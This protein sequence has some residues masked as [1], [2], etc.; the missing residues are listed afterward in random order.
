MLQ[1]VAAFEA[2]YRQEFAPGS[3]AAKRFDDNT[4]FLIKIEDLVGTHNAALGEFPD[5]ILGKEIDVST[6]RI[7]LRTIVETG[8]RVFGSEPERAKK[9]RLPKKD[10]VS[11]LLLDARALRHIAFTHQSAFVA[12]KMP[13]NFIEQ[14]DAEISAV[15]LEL[16]DEQG[17]MTAHSA[18]TPALNPILKSA[19]ANVRLLDAPIQTKF[20]ANPAVL[21]EWETA[22]HVDFTSSINVASPIDESV[23]NSAPTLEN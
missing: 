13:A 9:L 6:L 14:L 3:N 23:E 15:W 10:T 19:V 7:Q 2:T 12:K 1:N 18:L 8:Q 20:A 11:R 21:G 4:V 22:S 17:E 5:E 16:R